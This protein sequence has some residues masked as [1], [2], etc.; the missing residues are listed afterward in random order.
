MSIRNPHPGRTGFPWPAGLH[1]AAPKAI[2]PK[3]P[4]HGWRLSPYQ[5]VSRDA[6]PLVEGLLPGFNSSFCNSETAYALAI[7][8]L[9][10]GG[11]TPV[12]FCLFPGWAPR[13]WWKLITRSCPELAKEDTPRESSIDSE[14]AWE[15]S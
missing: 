10:E 8:S 14:E 11:R 6:G 12:F 9:A 1:S 5:T 15:V 4:R 2:G 7:M 3:K 13:T